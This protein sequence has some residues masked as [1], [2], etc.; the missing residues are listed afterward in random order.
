[1]HVLLI[2]SADVTARMVRQML[3]EPGSGAAFQVT[4]VYGAEEARA[5]LGA[6]GID[7]ILVDA[8]GGGT[9]E[10]LAGEG[11]F[12]R[13]EALVLLA[14]QEDPALVREVLLRGGQDCL[15][16]SA[17][18]PGW[19]RAALR[20][21]AIRARMRRERAIQEAHFHAVLDQS[22]DGILIV[23]REGAIRY[24]NGAA[25]VLLNRPR[26]ALEGALWGFPVGV[27]GLAEL[28]VH[29]APD[30]HRVVEM[31]TAPLE[32]E[33][34][35]AYIATLRDVTA[36]KETEE[37]LRASEARLR[38]V[39]DGSNDCIAA[40]YLDLTYLAFNEAYRNIMWRIFGVEV[41]VGM[42]LKE[43]TR[44]R[45]AEEE[46]TLAF[47]RRALEGETFTAEYTVGTL[48][49][50]GAVF[51]LLFSPIRGLGDR[52]I[53]A[54]HVMRDITERR[55]TLDALRR[56]T[57]RLRR[58]NDELARFADVAGHDL[59]EPLRSTSLYLE[60]LSER[61]PEH[62]SDE[63]RQL[64]GSAL[65]G[66]TR[67]RS[68]I[69]DLLEY[70]RV[71]ARALTVKQVEVERVVEQ[72]LVTMEGALDES[73]AEIVVGD[74]PTVKADPKQLRRVFQNL[75]SNAIKFRNEKTPR[76]EVAA[77][78]GDAAWIFSVADNGIGF[79][80]AY[81][82]HIFGMFERL[83]NRTAYEGTGMGLS[84]CEK[85]VSLHGGQ[86]WVEAAPGKG[87]TFF[88]SL[89]DELPPA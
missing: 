82:D 70:A 31:R 37:A 68:L 43:A 22:A 20:T 51:E 66:L 89:P 54:V 72:V 76:I 64:I 87:A 5:A 86:M 40:L 33:G 85:I 79:D 32:W 58:S 15:V 27:D 24:A 80:P 44:T 60:M 39:L 78:R 73:G 50:G 46:A 29:P 65:A 67:M 30:E 62:L 35:L 6:G 47:W 8:S 45:P 83:H 77:E 41:E 17:L 74:L 59:R 88:F 48:D 36:R 14:A 49:A 55:R 23:D 19:L 34:E 56:T 53:G 28:D 2:A 38:A 21:A 4:H 16:K 9:V 25:E 84:I 18:T 71:D 11:L 3:E 13:P 81:A 42:S 57:E 61:F 10:E 63:A 12:D 75:F 26:A 7:A 69:D 1:M 52:V